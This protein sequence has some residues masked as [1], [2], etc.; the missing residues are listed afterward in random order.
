MSLHDFHNIVVE[1][2]PKDVEIIIKQAIEAALG[3]EVKDVD[4]TINSG[5]DDRYGGYLAP[6]LSKVSVRLGNTKS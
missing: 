6:Y 3:K 4:F 2:S 5:M 1:L